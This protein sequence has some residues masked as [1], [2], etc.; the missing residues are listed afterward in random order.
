MMWKLSSI[1]LSSALLMAACGGA[2]DE[3]NE[4]EKE[5]VNGT[6]DPVVEE[7]T[8]EPEVMAPVINVDGEEIG[9]VTLTQGPSGV[10][11]DIDVS[12]LEPGEHGMHFHETGV[13]T[14]PDFK[15]SAGGHFNPTDKKHGLEN[16]EGHHAGD[17]ENLVADEEGNAKVTVTTDAVTLESGKENSLMDEDGSALIIHEGADD[18]ITDPAG[19]SGTPFACAEITSENMK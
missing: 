8:V 18:N 6:G 5:P 9:S 17:L 10:A 19:N 15:E 7:E 3:G 14:A 11:M 12:G 13:C 1:A 2:T 4:K 16:P